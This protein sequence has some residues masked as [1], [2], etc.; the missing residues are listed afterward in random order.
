MTIGVCGKRVKKTGKAIGLC[1]SY[2]VQRKPKI[3]M[4]KGK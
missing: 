1:I 3:K 2:C 4:E